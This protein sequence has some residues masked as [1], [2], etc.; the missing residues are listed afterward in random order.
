MQAAWDAITISQVF[1]PEQHNPSWLCR[2]NPPFPR[3]IFLTNCHFFKLQ[4]EGLSDGTHRYA[5]PGHMAEDLLRW[6]RVVIK[7]AFSSGCGDNQRESVLAFKTFFLTVTS[8]QERVIFTVNDRLDSR[9]H[10]CSKSH[11]FT[12]W[13]SPWTRR[14]YD[15]CGYILRGGYC[16]HISGVKP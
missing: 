5:A 4:S 3:A 6:Q 9:S 2:P 11:N 15:K 10:T 13:K 12:S 8:R 14:W 7:L 1:L 16:K